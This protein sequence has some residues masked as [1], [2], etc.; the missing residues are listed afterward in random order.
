VQAVADPAKS[1]TICDREQTAMPS[2]DSVAGRS[3]PGD[4]GRI[5]A[6]KERSLTSHLDWRLSNPFLQRCA[7]WYAYTR[8]DVGTV[9]YSGFNTFSLRAQVVSGAGNI[10]ADVA[11]VRFFVRRVASEV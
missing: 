6:L 10:F 9:P 8:I 1:S 4:S 5:F 3:G 11:H 7:N 2:A